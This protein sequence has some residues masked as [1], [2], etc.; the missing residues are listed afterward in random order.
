MDV[1]ANSRAVQQIHPLGTSG[2]NDRLNLDGR[3]AFRSDR[4][5]QSCGYAQL[6]RSGIVEAAAV[7]AAH[8]GQKVLPS[9]TYE[10][11]LLVSLNSSLPA[12]QALGIE[13]PAYVFFSLLG[14]QGYRMGVQRERFLETD[15]FI[16]DRDVLDFRRSR[17]QIGRATRHS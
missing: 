17:S 5:R 10:R 3:I 15:A 8:Q 12:L 9:F 1:Q 4:E 14:I 7:H 11:D 13:A 16:A 2:Y 6:F